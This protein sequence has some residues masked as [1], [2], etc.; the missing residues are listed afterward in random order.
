MDL[1]K[2]R[3]INNDLLNK[4]KQQI[5]IGDKYQIKQQP[6]KQDEDKMKETQNKIISLEIKK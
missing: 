1:D 3:N 5:V 2:K 4:V 6:I